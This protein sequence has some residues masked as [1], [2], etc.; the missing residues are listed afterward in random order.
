[1]LVCTTQ[2]LLV[3]DSIPDITIYDG[4]NTEFAINL[5]A[6]DIQADEELIFIIKNF[7][8]RNAPIVYSKILTLA[9]VN[10]RE[11]VIFEISPKEALLIKPK[12]KYSI[13]L[14]TNG[15]PKRLTPDGNVL[16]VYGGF[17]PEASNV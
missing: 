15:E 9:D 6:F 16:L 10:E 17:N 1:M 4:C 14:K 13:F 7:N 8:Y 5:Q 11:E 2:K 12:A 3:A